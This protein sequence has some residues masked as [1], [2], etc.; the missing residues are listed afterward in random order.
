[1]QQIS[2]SNRVL[3][4]TW[5]VKPKSEHVCDNGLYMVLRFHLGQQLV[6]VDGGLEGL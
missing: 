3:T 2:Y 1:M 5:L 4:I 6:L